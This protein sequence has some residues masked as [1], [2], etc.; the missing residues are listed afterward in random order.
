MSFNGAFFDLV[1]MQMIF[2]SSFL[3]SL[4]P[5]RCFRS[6]RFVRSSDG[7]RAYPAFVDRVGGGEYPTTMCTATFSFPAQCLFANFVS[8][9]SFLVLPARLWRGLVTWVTFDRASSLIL[10]LGRSSFFLHSLMA[11][12][13]SD[14]KC[15]LLSSSSW[16]GV[17]L[18]GIQ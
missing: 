5:R 13:F 3:A 11:A 4:L 16:C 18:T 17:L 1:S 2:F 14:F 12:S 9:H 8:P 15:T 6:L 10:F 7:I